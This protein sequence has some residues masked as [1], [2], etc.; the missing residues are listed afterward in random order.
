MNDTVK[1]FDTTLRDGEQ[2]PGFGMKP[3]QKIIMARALADLGVDVI[4]AGFANASEGDFDSVY[5]I[6]EEIKGPT[7]CSLARCNPSDIERAAAALKSAGENGR[8]H[9]FISTSDIHMREKLNMTPD[10]VIEQAVK[11]ITMACRHVDDIEFSAEDALRSDPEFLVQIFSAAID[12]GATTINVPDTVGYT[13]PDEMYDFVHYLH[14]NIPGI[15]QAIISVHCHNDLGMATANSMAAIKAGAR[16]VEGCINGIGE[17][18]GNAAI[19]E[20]VMALRTRP[21]RYGHIGTNIQTEKLGPTSRLL[22]SITGCEFQPNKAIVGRNAFSHESG[23]HQDGMIKS[24]QTYEIMTPAS[25][26]MG[27][28]NLV[29]GKHSGSRAVAQRIEKMTGQYVNPKSNIM[30]AIMQ[31]FKATAD[32][33][34]N[35]CVTDDVIRQI[36]T[37][38]MSAIQSA[39]KSFMALKHG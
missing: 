10:A 15:D 34:P 21:D 22:E 9:V 11:G 12:A 30:A 17:R 39:S 31:D 32:K 28:T 5:T 2:S 36:A 38:Y 7:I 37:P 1:I 4:E 14:S 24:A 33:T 26:G 18:A 6:A 8:I 27:E 29:L 25:V 16:Q 20:V 35:G 13:E 3:S 19:E 23:I